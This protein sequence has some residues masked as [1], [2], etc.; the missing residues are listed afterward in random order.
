[1]AIAVPIRM[2][3]SVRLTMAV[4]IRLAIAVGLTI[5]DSVPDLA[6]MDRHLRVGPKAQPYAAPLDFQNRDLEHDLQI[7][8]P[9]DYHAL[10]ILPR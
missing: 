9:T 5:T 3:I 10:P 2:A 1:M 4:P 8:R 6:A 7:L